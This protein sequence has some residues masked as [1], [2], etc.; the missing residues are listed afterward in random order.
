MIY[1]N[2]W[3]DFVEGAAATVQL[4]IMLPKYKMMIK[5]TRK[6]KIMAPPKLCCQKKNEDIFCECFHYIL[7]QYDLHAASKHLS[8]CH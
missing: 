7:T 1:H 2:G 4:I 8:H 3:M 6:Y 5:K